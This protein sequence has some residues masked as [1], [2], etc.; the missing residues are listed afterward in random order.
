[1]SN[2]GASSAVILLIS[3]WTQSGVDA[4]DLPAMRFEIR[5]TAIIH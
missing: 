2:L 4:L 1:M 3:V 5:V